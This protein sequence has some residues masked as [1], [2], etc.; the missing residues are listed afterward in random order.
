MMTNYFL[1]VT[2]Y[3]VLLAILIAT[4]KYGKLEG[5]F[6]RIVLCNEGRFNDK[7]KY[8]YSQI[9]NTEF[10]L[11]SKEYVRSC[12]FIKEVIN[13]CNGCLFIF[14]M[15]NPQFL[16]LFYKLKMKNLARTSIVQEGLASYNYNKYTLRSRLSRMREN[17]ITLRKAGIRDM[18]FYLYC[19]GVKG[20]MGKIFDYYNKAVDSSLV[21]SFYL[22]LPD[23]ALYGKNK[24]EKIPDF[25]ETSINRANAFF[26]YHK[27]HYFRK[28]DFVF[29]DQRIEGSIDFVI[30]LVR[31]FEGSEVY[32]KLH[33]TTKADM[34]SRYEALPRVHVIRDL[35]G[36][37]IELMLQNLHETIVLTPFSSALLI[38]NPNCGYYYMYKWLEKK[39]YNIE[40]EVLYTPGRHIRIVDSLEQIVLF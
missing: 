30:E 26:N 35:D 40:H 27:G 25:T 18:G 28:N 38:D 17:I 14:N 36:I 20:T 8:N 2:E 31:K 24:A 23:Y 11:Y 22:S 4:E 33:P 12:G 7:T 19:Y 9:E 15:N 32:I 3:H 34:I 39:G 13:N 5:G 16:Y 37:P 21:D 6:N 1:C 10:I 29:V